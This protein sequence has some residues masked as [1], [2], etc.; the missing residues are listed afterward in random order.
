MVIRHRLYVR[1]PSFMKKRLL[2]LAVLSSVP[3]L[4]WITGSFDFF[5]DSSFTHGGL[6]NFEL[7]RER[8]L[9]EPTEDF[10][11]LEVVDEGRVLRINLQPGVIPTTREDT[12]RIAINALHVVRSRIASNSVSVSVWLYG[13]ANAERSSLIG[14]AFYHTLT[15][16]VIFK[17]PEDLP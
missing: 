7:Y 10:R 14:M 2:I 3:L 4:A 17:Y 1:I 12:R 5:S 6:R 16:K 13:G 15:E 8:V 11:I 9:Q